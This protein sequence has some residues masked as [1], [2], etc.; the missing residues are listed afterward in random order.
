MKSGHLSKYFE[1]VAA[2]RL[3]SVEAD[4][5]VSNQ[6]EFNGSRALR[7]ILGTER[8]TDQ[9]ARFVWLGK[10]EEAVSENATVSWYDARENQPKRSAEYRLYFISNRVMDLAR[11]GDLLIVAKRPS[12]ELLVLIVAKDSSLESQLLWLFDVPE[13]IGLQF[14]YRSVRNDSERSVDFAVRF[15]LD[16]LG[17]DVE[18]TETDLLDRII[19]PLAGKFPNTK[20]FS[21]L[22]RHTLKGDIAIADPDT[23]LLA[24][25]E[26]EEKLF[27]RLERNIVGERLQRGFLNDKGE[28]DVDG[29]IDFSLSVQNRRKS[30]VGYALENHIEHIFTEMKVQFARNGET[31]NKSKPD[32]LFPGLA[33]YRN[34]EFPA[35]HLTVL[36]VKSTCKDRWRQ[37]LSEAQRCHTKHLL[38]L[39]PGISENQTNEMKASQLQLILPKA[40]HVTYR[41]SQQPWLQSLAAFIDLVRDKQKLVTN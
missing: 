33:H 2:K 28:S 32:F 5:A 17:I 21:K 31:E 41:P 1:Q 35:N 23:S 27:R 13:Q 18:E 37:V 8:L 14:E 25:I 4:S 12:G 38:T 22:A 19:L 30:R 34:K 26:W 9:P 29:F 10:D 6:H 36:G 7:Q 20:E 24:W 11:P 15:I 40:L 16:E 39:E 3:S